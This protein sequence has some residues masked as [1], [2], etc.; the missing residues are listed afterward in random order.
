MNNLRYPE[1]VKKLGIEGKVFVS[2]IIEKDGVVSN[3][4]LERPHLNC[5]ACDS[6]ALRLIR[7]MPQ[8]KAG[9]KNGVLVRTQ[10]RYPIV[11]R[12]ED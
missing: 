2:F 3:V 9:K 6:E 5:P 1:E 4:Q 12:L 10:M 11:F 7:E 8:W